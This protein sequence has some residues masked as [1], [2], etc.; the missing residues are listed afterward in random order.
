M[1][2]SPSAIETVVLDP[3]T[4]ENI[5]EYQRVALAFLASYRNLTTR[6]NYA[7]TLKI[8]FEWCHGRNLEPLREVKRPHIELWMRVMEEQQGLAKR[9][10]AGRMNALAGYYKTAV[11]DGYIE[12]SPMQWIKRPRIERLS[13]TNAPSRTELHAMLKAAEEHSWRDLAILCLLGLNGL[14]VS[15]LVGIDIEDI[16]VQ[17]G[18]KLITVRRKFDK[19]QKIPLAYRAAWAVE[20]VVDGR[21]TGPLFVSRWN[22]DKRLDRNDVGRLV[23]KY[24]K[25][26]GVTKRLS[27][28]SLRHAF[29]TLSLNAGVSPRDVQHSA[30]HTD[31]RSTAYYDRKRDDPATNATHSLTAFVEGAD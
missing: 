24:A 30:G 29:V 21:V 25:A 31:P 19:V 8:Y 20:Q 12:A 23:K 3:F 5:P 17:R 26:A 13:S 22:P 2:Y 11:M 16:E 6:K 1:P 10:I 4:D 14:R 28:H 9:T 7:A 15:E 27:P 18:Y